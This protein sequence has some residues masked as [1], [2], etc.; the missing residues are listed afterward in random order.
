MSSSSG[1]SGSSMIT[2]EGSCR[3]ARARAIRNC[4]SGLR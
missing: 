4:S 3:K 2:I 1:E